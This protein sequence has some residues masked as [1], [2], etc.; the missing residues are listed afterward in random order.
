MPF[1][2]VAAVLAFVAIIC[3]AVLIVLTGQT[4]GIPFGRGVAEI[5]GGGILIF[6]LSAIAAGVAA[7]F[8]PDQKDEFPGL[9]IGVVAALA[10]TGLLYL[11]G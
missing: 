1:I 4:P 6:A 5:A 2:K 3:R 9:K 7:Y 11:L 10:A 8:A